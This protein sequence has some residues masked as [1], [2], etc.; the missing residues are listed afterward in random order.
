MLQMKASA[1]CGYLSEKAPDGG[2]LL[3]HV[4]LFCSGDAVRGRGVWGL[5]LPPVKRCVV[6]PRMPGLKEFGMPTGIAN[7]LCMTD[8]Q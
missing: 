2:P 7:T 6:L 8:F 1:E 5:H 3:R 4:A